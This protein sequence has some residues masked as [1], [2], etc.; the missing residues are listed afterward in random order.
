M[1]I[2]PENDVILTEA[3]K[4]TIL[5]GARLLSVYCENLTG[6]LKCPFRTPRTIDENDN[7]IY[8]CE[9]RSFLP[10]CWSVPEKWQKEGVTDD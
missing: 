2:N 8:G 4:Q 3:E 5:E 10:C 9:C 7:V 6:C 1:Q